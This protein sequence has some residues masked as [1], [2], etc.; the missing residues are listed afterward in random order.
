MHWYG[1]T[2]TSLVVGAIVGY[3][4]TLAARKHGQ[5]DSADAGVAASDPG[6]SVSDLR[7]QGVVVPISAGPT[8][9]ASRDQR[10][11]KIA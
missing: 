8:P 6:N 3:L 1:W 11:H 7:S 9:A 4:A 5:K 2:A 10:E